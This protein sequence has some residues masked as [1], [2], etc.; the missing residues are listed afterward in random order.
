M[1]RC[2]SI[3]RSVQC[4]TSPRLCPI[5]SLPWHP[6][7]AVY[8]QPLSCLMIGNHGEATMLILSVWII[9]F[10]KFLG[11]RRLHPLNAE[12]P[13]CHQMVRLHYNE[14]GRRHIFA[15]AHAYSRALYEG[16]RYRAHRI[17]KIKCLGSDI[18]ARFDPRPNEKQ[19]FRPP[20]SL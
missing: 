7:L 2:E 11:R 8:G 9:E 4:P 19:H 5:S 6:K 12:C 1:L 16:A 15:H 18:P 14:A 13:I 17:S 20:K 3:G 10:I